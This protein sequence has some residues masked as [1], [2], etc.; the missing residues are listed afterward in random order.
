MIIIITWFCHL[1]KVRLILKMD[2]SV[3]EYLL[4][5]YFFSITENGN[6][7]IWVSSKDKQ[8]EQENSI[9]DWNLEVNK[10]NWNWKWENN[11]KICR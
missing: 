3:T 7:Q 10:Q 5:I 11:V 4:Q 1:I 8:N 6:G 2:S 9:N